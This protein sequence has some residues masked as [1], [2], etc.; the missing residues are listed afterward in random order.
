MQ[1]VDQ[2]FLLVKEIIDSQFPIWVWSHSIVNTLEMLTSRY[3][4]HYIKSNVAVVCA[5]L[6]GRALQ[7]S[8]SI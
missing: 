1:L 8:V 3:G 2:Y 7:F 6:L 5:G 4:T